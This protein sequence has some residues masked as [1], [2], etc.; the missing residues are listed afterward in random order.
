MATVYLARDPKLNRPVAIKVLRP[1]L[2]DLLGRE[3]FLREIE[4]AAR[5]QHA[6]VLPLYDSGSDG[7]FLY[8]VMPY[9]EGESLRDRLDREKQLPVE[10]ALQIA[11]EVAEGLSYAHSLGVVHRDIKPGNILLS[12]GHT[13]V[14]D[15]GIARAIS[16]AGGTQLTE[17]GIAIGTPAYMSPEQGSGQDAVDGRS[18]LYSLGCVLYEM[19]AGDPPFSARTMQALIARHQQERPPSL[20]VVRPTVSLGVQRVIETTLAKVPADRYST[21]LQFVAALEGARSGRVEHRRRLLRAAVVVAVLAAAGALWQFVFS[22]S[23][24]VDPNRV[25]VFPLG[26]TPAQATQGGAGVMVSLM[27]GSALEYTEPLQWIDGLPLLDT[28]LRSDV[29]LLTAAEARRISRARG[30]RWYL[31]GTVVRHGD[32]TTVVVRMN[33]AKGDSVVGRASA[34]RVAPEAARAGLEAVNQLLPRLLAPGRRIDLAALTER[35]PAA[36]ASWLQGEREYRR[37]NFD[38]AL[39]FLRRA[40][41]E[42]SALVVAALR[43]AQAASWMSQLPEAAQFAD[44]ALVRVRQLP[45]RQGDF[46]RGLAAYLH[47]QADAAVEWLTR[48]LSTTPDWNEAHMTLGEVYHHLLPSVMG[49]LDSLAE[50]E[51]TVA[52]ADTGFAPPFFHLAEIAIRSGDVGEA[53]RAVHQFERFGNRSDERRELALMLT[54]ARGGRDGV[55]WRTVTSE[56]P[57]VVLNA[58]KMLSVAGAFLGCAEDASRAL[59][60]TPAATGLQRGAF[61]MLQDLL[62]AQGRET[63]IVSLVDSLANAGM[64]WATTAYLVDALSATPGFDTRVPETIA[65]F[66]SVYGAQYE[67]SLDIRRLLLLGAWYGRTLRISDAT[68]LHGLLARRAAKTPDP[69]ARLYA[70]ALEAHLLLARGDSDAALT[71][72]EGLTPTA[73]WDDLAWGWAE[74]LPVERITRAELLLSR[75]RYQEALD[76]SSAFDH[77]TPIVYLPFLPASLT[78]R[79]RAATAMARPEEAAL[80]RDR[81]V[82]LGRADLLTERN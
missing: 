78:L 4:I 79:H 20:R 36:V 34:T 2:S 23:P 69:E 1:E 35:R 49:P 74:S 27:I 30:A 13:L 17:R 65:S 82:A 72:F 9:V 77:P 68:R 10:E 15:F 47:G 16:A 33:D 6:N 48:A 11:R 53:E 29:G 80:Y 66:R 39:V 50:S 76:V 14:A 7:G 31:D 71:R 51:F 45:G 21:P 18:D 32:S 55:D 25:V 40:V 37:G 12:G 26:E 58:A 42:D 24:L 8:Y 43:G 54:C 57:L 64:W 67:D 61:L 38:S 81:L 46:A 41:R 60:A 28:R 56:S 59:L 62:A 73:W 75:G 5:L 44:L 70:H 22:P 3:R 19:L 63:A 52:A